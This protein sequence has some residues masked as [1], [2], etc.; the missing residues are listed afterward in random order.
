M[1]G[2]AI[3]NRGVYSANQ[4]IIPRF[5]LVLPLSLLT[6]PRPCSPLCTVDCACVFVTADSEEYSVRECLAA[7]LCSVLSRSRVSKVSRH[8]RLGSPSRALRTRGPA[9]PRCVGCARSSYRDRALG[10]CF[11]CLPLALR[12]AR[13]AF[14]WGWGWGWGCGCGCDWDCGCG[15]TCG[16]PW[17]LDA[18]LP[19]RS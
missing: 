4:E 14:G 1:G 18:M 7:S 8:S 2:I 10:Y 5:S 12:A 19:L 3:A 11:T 15:C 17:A 6:L 9:R 13:D 16:V